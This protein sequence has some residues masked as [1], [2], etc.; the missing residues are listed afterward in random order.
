MLS[1]ML[2]LNCSS[3]HWKYESLLVCY[4]KAYGE[5]S[6]MYLVLEGKYSTTYM[7]M[8]SFSIIPVPALTSAFNPDPSIAK[9][10]RTNRAVCT[11]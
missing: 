3:D 5:N 8:F 11:S 4:C 1:L 6:C 9:T 7:Y 2:F 10:A